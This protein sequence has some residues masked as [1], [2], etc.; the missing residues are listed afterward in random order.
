MITGAAFLRYITLLLSLVSIISVTLIGVTLG[1]IISLKSGDVKK[2]LA[3][4]RS[5][6]FKCLNIL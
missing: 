1:V 4:N 6:A 3:E 2:F 5:S